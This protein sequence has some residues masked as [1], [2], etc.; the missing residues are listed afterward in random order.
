M[1]SLLET[2]W[3]VWNSMTPNGILP[4]FV[5]RFE[6]PACWFWTNGAR[7]WEMIQAPLLEFAWIWLQLAHIQKTDQNIQKL[8]LLRLV[9]F[10]QPKNCEILNLSF[11]V[12][13]KFISCEYLNYVIQCPDHAIPATQCRQTNK[14][15][16]LFSALFFFE[17]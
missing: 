3:E 14:F 13:V 11:K 7:R 10:T 9:G 15:T 8:H 16:Q 1:A 6:Q 12:R 4:N 2:V 5:T 17:I